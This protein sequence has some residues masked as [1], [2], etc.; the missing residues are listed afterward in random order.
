M[1]RLSSSLTLGLALFVP[2][3]WF[4]FF[5]SMTVFILATA[6]EDIPVSNPGVFKTV[7]LICFLIFALLIYKTLMK[8]KR[9][10]IED[11]QL[12][13]T[14]Y[15]KTITFPIQ[16]VIKIK[17]QKILGMTL[18]T[19]TIGYKTYFGKKIRF[20]TDQYKSDILRQQL[21]S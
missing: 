21:R 20:I 14:N 7:L 10:E 6:D 11:Q 18:V 16:H 2:V 3:F 8:L 15:F 9:V 5:G 12:F 19:M 4:V 1:I 13:V 17:E